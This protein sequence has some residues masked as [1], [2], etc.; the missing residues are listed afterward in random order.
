MRKQD[1]ER[2][3]ER[4]RQEHIRQEERRRYE[5]E[6]EWPITTMNRQMEMLQGLVRDHTEMEAKRVRPHESNATH[7][8]RRYRV[9]SNNF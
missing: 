3:K 5:E 4:E 9:V 1:A 6:S 2:A 7:R 8:H